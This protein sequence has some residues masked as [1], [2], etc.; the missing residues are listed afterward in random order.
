MRA[1]CNHCGAEAPHVLGKCHVCGLKVC[2]KCGNTQHRKGEMIVVHNSCLS[3]LDD[4]SG[5][6]MIKFVQ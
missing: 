3:D 6:S 1:I 5:F 2:S 4:E